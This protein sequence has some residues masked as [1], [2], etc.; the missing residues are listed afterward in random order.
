[1]PDVLAGT[2]GGW[3]LVQHLLVLKRNIA[4]REGDIDANVPSK[5]TLA[6]SR[7]IGND[8]KGSESIV[9]D[10][11]AVLERAR[12]KLRDVLLAAQPAKPP[13]KNKVRL[14]D[15]A[16]KHLWTTDK[17]LKRMMDVK[18]LIDQGGQVR[19]KGT[20]TVAKTDWKTTFE[21]IPNALE[22]TDEDA[23]EPLPSEAQATSTPKATAKK[24]PAGKGKKGASD[25]DEE[26]QA[27]FNFGM[28]HLRFIVYL[29]WRAVSELLDFATSAPE[30]V[31]EEKGNTEA[32]LTATASGDGNAT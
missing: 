12:L 13:E 16:I 32:T 11:L 3:D 20:S 18:A 2:A 14:I 23:G 29:E 30:A 31:K 7:K 8:K 25:G 1:V 24:K 9:I 22:T 19:F 6:Y 5:I 4:M 26:L 17:S 21:V 15:D 28:G 27:S 10:W